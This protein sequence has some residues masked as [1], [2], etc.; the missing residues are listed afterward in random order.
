MKQQLFFDLDGTIIDSSE[1]IYSSIRYALEK[2]DMNL[3]TDG[4]R[5]FVG[6][7]LIN[8]FRDLGFTEETAQRAVKYYRE[9]YREKG[10]FQITPYEKIE[11]T[12]AELS[13]THDVFIATS[14]PEIFAKRNFKLLRFLQITSKEFTELILKISGEK[15]GSPCICTRE[16]GWQYKCLNDW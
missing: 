8:S 14:K 7:P 16:G 3:S 5:A 1:G 11:T 12:L 6:P 4:L 2:L 10:M 9:N 15:S 13:E